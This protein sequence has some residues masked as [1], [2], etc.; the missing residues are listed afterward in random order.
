MP[1]NCYIQPFSGVCCSCGGSPAKIQCEG[2]DGHC[3]HWQVTSINLTKQ[4]QEFLRDALAR[5]APEF[6]AQGS[7]EEKLVYSII[8]KL[9]LPQ[10]GWLR[11]RQQT[12]SQ[13]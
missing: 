13:Q 7:E 12:A 5:I 10:D 4:E 8:L 3:H 6:Y 1:H 2:H 11:E 9:N